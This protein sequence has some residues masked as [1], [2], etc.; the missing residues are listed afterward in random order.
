[1]E[2]GFFLVSHKTESKLEELLTLIR[3][4]GEDVAQKE[5]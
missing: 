2:R 5:K 4:K 1:M 3:D